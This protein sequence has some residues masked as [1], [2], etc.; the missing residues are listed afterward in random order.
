M[1]RQYLVE[2]LKGSFQFIADTNKPFVVESLPNGGTRTRIPGRFG[3]CN[4]V[5]GNNRRYGVNVWEKNFTTGSPL[6]QAIEENA[7]WGLLEHPKDGKVDLNSPICIRA[8]SAKLQEGKDKVGKPIMEVVGEISIV[9]TDEGTK[10]KALI[11]EGYNPRVSSRGFGSLVRAGDGVDDVQ[12]DYICEGWDVVLRPSFETA[13]LSP[14]RESAPAA[15]TESK[16]IAENQPPAQPTA[17]PTVPVPVPAPAVP[18]QPAPAPAAPKITLE[19]EKPPTSEP[20]KQKTAQTMNITEIKSQ[21][22]AMRSTDPSKLDPQRFAEGMSALAGLHQDVANYVAE[23]AKRN[24]DGMKLHKEIEGV[25]TRWS[26]CQLA[27]GRRATKLNEDNTKLMQVTKAV[28]QTALNLKKKIG[29]AVKQQTRQTALLNEVTERGQAWRQRSKAMEGHASSYKRRFM[30]ASEALNQFATKYKTD[31]TEMGKRLITLEFV[32]KAETPEIKEM[33]KEAVKPKHIV[34]IRLACEGKIDAPTAKSIME[35][36][37]DLN[38]ALKAIR[39]AGKVN[40]SRDDDKP[41]QPDTKP[42][43][44]KPTTESVK[45]ISTKPGDPRQLTEAIG[46][47]ERLSKSSVA[48]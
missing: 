47:V 8:I 36:T 43:T 14:Q 37:T 30:M 12:D 41:K 15:T 16:V 44:A 19:A 35:G 7:A 11:E 5:N 34:A 40:E 6:M 28:I 10:L 1:A 3:I 45:I 42:A 17:P 4:E 24:Y 26:E 38:E 48:V 32:E 22:T 23:D 21:I 46:M 25:E 20:Q 29:E 2:G 27:P 13:V 39:S 31:V 9:G 18:A 33:L